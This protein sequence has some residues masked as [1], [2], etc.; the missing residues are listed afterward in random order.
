[1]IIEP[2]LYISDIHLGRVISQSKATIYSGTTTIAGQLSPYKFVHIYGA[3]S[4]IQ[5]TVRCIK[6]QNLLNEKLTPQRTKPPRLDVNGPL[7]RFV[8][9]CSL[10]LHGPLVPS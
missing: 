6:A 8:F 10:F 9:L 2:L 3:T 5:S 1:M 4:R 7:T